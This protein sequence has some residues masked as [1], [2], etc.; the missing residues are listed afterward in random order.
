M[1]VTEK[2]ECMGLETWQGYQTSISECANKCK[3]KST[4]FLFGTN[5]FGVE[6]CNSDGCAC[7]CETGANSDGSCDMVPHNGYRLYKFETLGSYVTLYIF[8]L[9]KKFTDYY[10]YFNQWQLFL[11]VLEQ[12]LCN[13]DHNN[14][15][16]AMSLRACLTSLGATGS[17]EIEYIET[18]YGNDDYLNKVCEAVDLSLIYDKSRT[19]SQP[20]SCS[21]KST[22]MYPSHCGQGWLGNDCTNGCGN[23]NYDGFYCKGIENN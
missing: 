8:I 1:L 13:L 15:M 14:Y 7:M 19:E 16:R 22:Y 4:V 20:D 6:R 5:D 10:L 3:S 18:A 9:I 12:I 11:I 17:N 21:G 23:D 2:K